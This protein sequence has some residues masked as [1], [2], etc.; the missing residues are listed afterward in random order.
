MLNMFK[1][2]KQHWSIIFII[3]GMVALVLGLSGFGAFSNFSLKMVFTM[4]GWLN[5]L[6][7]QNLAIIFKAILN[8]AQMYVINLSSDAFFL[9]DSNQFINWQIALAAFLAPLSTV[10]ALLGAFGYK[11]GHWFDLHVKSIWQKTDFVFIGGGN[12]AT[13]ISKKVC[14][15]TNK[16]KIIGLTLHESAPLAHALDKLD[17]NSIMHFSDAMNDEDLRGLSL[18]KAKNIWI[19]VGNDLLSIYI[20]RRVIELVKTKP[21]TEKVKININTHDLDFSRKTDILFPD[22]DKTNIN[23]EMVPITRIMARMLY[24]NFQPTLSM[25]QIV[26]HI[27]I[28]GTSD[29][30]ESLIIHAVQHC[31]YD[32]FECVEITLAGK[33]VTEKLSAMRQKFV[34]LCESSNHPA[35]KDLLPLAKF[36]V[37]DCDEDEISLD[38]WSEIQQHQSFNTI[39]VACKSDEETLTVAT[40]IAAL[41]EVSI[42]YEELPQKIIACYWQWEFANKNDSPD[43]IARDLHNI[44]VYDI[45]FNHIHSAIDY[46]DVNAMFIRAIYDNYKKEESEIKVLAKSANQIVDDELRKKWIDHS[47]DGWVSVFKDAYRWSTRLGGDH[48]SIKLDLLQRHA[49]CNQDLANNPALV[50]KLIS[51]NIDKL[52]RIEHKRFITERIIEGWL[53]LPSRYKGSESNYSDKTYN[54]QK[55]DLH[56]NTTLV[57]FDTLD[58]KERKKDWD[59]INAIPEIMRCKKLMKEIS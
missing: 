50:E 1:F 48:I 56:V 16:I 2:I 35:F 14:K 34:G 12:V 9:Q 59:I 57:P 7:E 6:A 28:V 21:T 25:L 33:G 26:P 53:P 39:F 36:N 29:L 43:F 31:V 45:S 18:H 49:K 3:I 37:I 38:K 41:R 52:S 19:S 4:Q 17:C 55:A 40:R 51:E 44:N 27:L 15:D 22:L 54:D 24:L 11:F 5:I 46:V 10:G 42:R 58:E 23:L 8:T 20:A 32:E 30:A 13:G 47:K